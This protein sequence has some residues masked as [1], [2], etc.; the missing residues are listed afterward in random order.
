MIGNALAFGSG[1]VF[2]VGLAVS[3]MTA[4]SNVIG[5]L[6]LAGAWQPAL[7]LV[8]AGAITV[9]ATAHALGRRMA[10]PVIGPAFASFAQSRVDSRLMV[11]SAIFGAGW[12]LAGYC[13]GPALV[14]SVTGTPSTVAFTVTMLLSL[15]ATRY[16][17]GRRDQPS[18][19][20]A[21]ATR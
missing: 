19:D 14:S 6:D 20:R 9:Y 13:P 1:L 17:D 7:A 12:G 8:M 15:W 5:F 3:G 4:P 11:G 21:R 18:F 16:M 10:K 2:A